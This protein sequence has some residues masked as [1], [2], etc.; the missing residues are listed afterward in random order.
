VTLCRDNVLGRR[1]AIKLI[2]EEVMDPDSQARFEREV[3]AMAQLLHPNVVTIFDIGQENGRYFLVLEL[4]EGGSV[5]ELISSAAEGRLDVAAALRIAQDTARGLVHAHGHGILHR[6]VKPGNI[7][8]TGEGLAKLGDFGLAY[9]GGGVRLTR[10]GMMVG[11]VAYMAPEVALG[12][13]ADERSD[14]YMLG[15]SLYEMVTGRVP[16]QGDDP[17]RVIFSH[18]N[19]LPLSPQRLVPDL[20]P[21]LETLITRLLAKDPEQR[22]DSASAVLSALE[23]IG[24]G[25]VRESPLQPTPSCAEWLGDR[26]AYAASTMPAHFVFGSES[27]SAQAKLAVS[28][29][30]LTPGNR[31]LR[32]LVG[33][34]GIGNA[35]VQVV[36]RISDIDSNVELAA[37]ADR[38]RSSGGFGFRDIGRDVG[39]QLIREMLEQSASSIIAEVKESFGF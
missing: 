18:I 13:Q 23:S 8:M 31:V 11:T 34:L 12:R 26:L 35:Q 27:H 29:T 5:E 20:P 7:W 14:L 37:F 15:A 9:L 33:E 21:A 28:I 3:Q 25:A 17:V 1:V 10:A 38:K 16:F 24:V 4:M 22:P 6:D 32:M 30:S 39:P 2:K 19:D 36:G